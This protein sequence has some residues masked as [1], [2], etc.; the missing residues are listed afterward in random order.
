MPE[1]LNNNIKI[2]IL[3]E[4]STGKSHN[5]L[6][7]SEWGFSVYIQNG[8][9]NILLDTGNTDIYWNNAE[10]L[11]IDLNQT[12]YIIL[13]HHHWDHINGLK[14]HKFNEKKKLI[15]HPLV[16]A[17]QEADFREK[18]EM[19]FNIISKGKPYEFEP[20]CFF[21]GE[22]PRKMSFEK[23]VYKDD[24]MKDDTAIVFRTPKGAVVI[25]G[26]A[27]SG[28]CNICEYA[29]EVTGQNLYAVIGGFHMISDDGDSADET[30][31]YF[32]KETVNK[33]YPMHCI[34][35]TNMVKFFNEFGI[36]K[37]ETGDLIELQ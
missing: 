21:L 35:F 13:S 5:K 3:T 31:N 6:C 37:I 34:D 24:P 12:D 2:T 32:K 7:R 4:N 16:P 30:I 20:G 29:K 25:S 33:L 17:K 18:L 11:V 23:G 1:E 9:K 8:N 28:I 15:C 26:C 19:D 14:Y 22:I 10:K 27:H 36:K